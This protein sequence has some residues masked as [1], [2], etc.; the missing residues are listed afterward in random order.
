MTKPL[1]KCLATIFKELEFLSNKK[2]KKWKQILFPKSPKNYF[3]NGKTQ[4]GNLQ[5]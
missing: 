2:K 3:Q 1:P 5:R 4:E